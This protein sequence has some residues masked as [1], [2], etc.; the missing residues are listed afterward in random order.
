MRILVLI[1]TVGVSPVVGEILPLCDFFDCPFSVLSCS[2]L[3]LA[4][5]LNH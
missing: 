1:G 4:P 2:F 5:R 3:D